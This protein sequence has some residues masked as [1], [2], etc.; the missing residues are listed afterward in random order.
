MT[1]FADE[2]HIKSQSSV[3]GLP[4][5]VWALGFVS[6]LMDISSEMIHSLL[7]VFLVSGLGI[8]AAALGLLEGTAEG[9]VNVIKIFS[10]ALSDWLGKRKMLALVGYGMAALTKPLFPLAKSFGVV[11]AARVIDRV[12]KGVR[13][14]PRD[15]LVADLTPEKLRGAGYGL[16]QG[17]DTT[18]AVIGPL[19]AIFLMLAFAG[20]FRKVLWVAVVPALICVALLVF[21]VHEPPD[22]ARPRMVRPQLRWQELGYFPRA[23][24]FVVFIG[25][26][27][28]LARL[29]EAFLILRASN[30]GLS[31]DY[32]PLAL[33]V[34]NV[35]YAVSSYPAGR[36]SDRVDRRMVLAIGGISLIV[37]DVLLARAGGIAGLVAGICFW[38]LHMGFS[39]GLLA[40]LIADSAPAE[41]RG[42]AFGIFGLVS[43]ITLLVASLLAGELW[44]RIGASA[45]FY[46]G[47]CF[48]ALGV[49][50]LLWQLGS[51]IRTAG[52]G[53]NWQALVRLFRSG[54]SGKDHR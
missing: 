54:G 33:V 26:V 19:G 3:L 48:A 29:S 31:N 42:N 36:L 37:S 13:G 9:V 28:T 53:N 50:G 32:V 2:M 40:T 22:S 43:G 12:G 4:R 46:A 16:R 5:S 6:M 8:S 1:Q 47:A 51:T 34:M 44:D 41:R 52:S 17:L 18:G 7:P 30:L 11:F 45:T 15:A 21:F 23:F 24:W 49:L 27:F 14:A 25:A 35:V 20:D 39:Q 38:G 10:G